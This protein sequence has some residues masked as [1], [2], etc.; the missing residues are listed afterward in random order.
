MNEMKHGVFQEGDKFV[1]YFDGQVARKARLE[2]RANSYFAWMVKTKGSDTKPTVKVAP[3]PKET[4]TVAYTAPN[5][6][7]YVPEKDA[8]FIPFG[9]FTKLNTI[10]KSGAFFP[11]FITG[12]TGNGKSTMVEQSCAR[13][14]RKYIRLQIN[15]QSDE[16]QLIGSKTLVDGNIQIVEGPVLIALRT[17]SVLL[18]DEL[19]AG[20]PNMI[21]CLQSILEGKPYYFKLK[22]EMVYPQPG[23]T[24]IATANTK[25]RGS[26]SGKYIG[27]QMLNEAFLERFPI[28]IEQEYP[29]AAYELKI[30][31]G[32]MERHN[33]VDETFAETLVKW[34]DTI[35]RTFETGA[36]DDLITTR[37]LLQIVQTYAIFKDQT[38]SVTLACNRFDQITKQTFIET[39][40]KLLPSEAPVVDEIP[41]ANS[42]L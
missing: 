31:K 2:E 27:T 40:T 4:P 18:L 9:D 17:G 36:I 15:S 38:L 23:F 39:F 12:P 42:N 22:N 21:L 6:A 20:D 29:S 16:D 19:D 32:A 34:S 7:A 5:T 28:T 24:I 1:V 13:N 26:D 8:H 30:V 11:V 3:Q 37:R 33:C 25:G 41:V 14:G 10:I 35:R